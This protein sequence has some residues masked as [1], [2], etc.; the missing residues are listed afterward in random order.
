MRL[1]GKVSERSAVRAV[2][3]RHRNQPSGD[4]QQRREHNDAKYLGQLTQVLSNRALNEVKVGY[5]AS[6]STSTSLTTWSK[7]WQAPTAS[8]P[9]A[10][11]ITFTRLLDSPATP[12][13]RATATRTSTTFRDDFTFSYDARRPSRPEG[14]RRVS[15]TCRTTAQLQPVRRHDRRANGGP[16]PPANIEALFPGP[17]QRRHLEPGGDLRITTRYTIGVWIRQR[18]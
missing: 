8:R 5:A 6:G 9:T 14:R 3:R 17:V 12:T 16:I 7:H 11:R 13:A 1:M 18:S 10:P 15:C 4:R 2:R